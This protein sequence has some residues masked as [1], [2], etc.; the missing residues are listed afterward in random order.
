M[1][2]GWMLMLGKREG[3]ALEGGTLC[4]LLMM[5]EG[6]EGGCKVTSCGGF[7]RMEG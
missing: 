1:L 7:V 6:G 2:D 5:G 4:R 3:R